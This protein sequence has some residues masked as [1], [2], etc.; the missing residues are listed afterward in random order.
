LNLNGSGPECSF[1]FSSNWVTM[2]KV[3][4]WTSP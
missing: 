3:K 4:A 1:F 2:R